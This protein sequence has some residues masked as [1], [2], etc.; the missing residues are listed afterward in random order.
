MTN[1]ELPLY[2]LSAQLL[3][4]LYNLF[5]SA[6][7]QQEGEVS[8]REKILYLTLQVIKSFSFF[9]GSDDSIVK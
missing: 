6:E 1:T 5:T 4:V 2:K 8:L 3:P 9:D 7:E